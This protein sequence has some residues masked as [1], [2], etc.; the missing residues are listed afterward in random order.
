MLGSMLRMGVFGVGVIWVLVIF[1]R[2]AGFRLAELLLIYQ[3]GCH[4]Q[5]GG[6]PI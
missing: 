2:R 3:L 5:G 4:C 1:N 6:L